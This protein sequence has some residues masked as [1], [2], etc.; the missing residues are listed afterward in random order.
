[1]SRKTMSRLHSLRCIC[2]LA[3]RSAVPGVL[4]ACDIRQSSRS[5][6]TSGR[7]GWKAGKSS[8]LDN[9]GEIMDALEAIRNRRSVRRYKDE[10]I[11]K[12]DLETIVDAGRLAATG[13]NK[14]PWDFVV[15]TGKP[16]I[17][18]FKS[19][20]PWIGGASAVIVVV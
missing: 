19:S 13:S 4:R 11:P 7:S 20:G 6:T 17:A 1:M 10:V 9:I 3:R 18:N 16:M 2:P 14:Q 15:V 12:S 8:W 5:G